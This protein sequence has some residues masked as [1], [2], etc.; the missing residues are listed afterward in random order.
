MSALARHAWWSTATLLWGASR[1]TCYHRTRTLRKTQPWEV[2]DD[3]ANHDGKHAVVVETRRETLKQ[4]EKAQ[5]G[6]G[7]E[8]RGDTTIPMPIAIARPSTID[9]P[10][11][12]WPCSWPHKSDLTHNSRSCTMHCYGTNASPTKGRMIPTFR[13]PWHTTNGKGEGIVA[14]CTPHRRCLAVAAVKQRCLADMN[15]CVCP[16]TACPVDHRHTALERRPLDLLSK[17][18]HPAENPAMGSIR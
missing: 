18:T 4:R 14:A 15:Q 6:K 3:S 17:D 11:P 5:G 1:S 2:F 9:M 7:A 12:S 16:S 10:M 8:E 13:E